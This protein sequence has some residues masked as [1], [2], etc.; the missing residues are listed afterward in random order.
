MKIKNL[1]TM[2]LS[3]LLFYSCKKDK[4]ENVTISGNVRNDCTGIGFANVTVYLINNYSHS[5]L[6]NKKNSSDKTTAITNSNGDF[7][8]ND[9]PI[10][11]IVYILKMKAV[12]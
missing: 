9:Y 6:F 11:V 10:I 5:S 8:F 4:V 3:L 7:V 2:M 1:I 12:I